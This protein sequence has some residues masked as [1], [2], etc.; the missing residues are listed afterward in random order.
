M[1]VVQ[2][3]VRVLHHNLSQLLEDLE[4]F[5]QAGDSPRRAEWGHTA[6]AGSPE[7]GPASDIDKAR[8]RALL[9]EHD[10]MPPAP[11]GSR[12]YAQRSLAAQIKELSG[13]TPHQARLALA[14]ASASAKRRRSTSGPRSTSGK[15]PPDADRVLLRS[16]I[17]EYKAMKPAAGGSDTYAKRRLKA[18]VK[19][20]VGMTALQAERALD[21][22]ATGGGP[23][24]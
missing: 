8:L 6:E 24:A 15:L 20:L 18:R 22:E 17:D 2:E 13:M 7:D 14:G 9:E 10:A 3:V 1:P 16:L 23:H 21:A 19:S 4:P 5:L 11:G 12:T